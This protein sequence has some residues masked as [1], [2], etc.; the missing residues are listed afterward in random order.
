[1]AYQHTFVVPISEQTARKRIVT[2]YTRAGYQQDYCKEPLMI[3]KRGSHIGSWSSNPVNW[4]SVA[5][6]KIAPKSGFVEVTVT[7]E[8]DYSFENVADPYII[9]EV[10]LLG[11]VLAKD[12]YLPVTIEH[13]TRK[14]I[15][16]YARYFCRDLA[17][18]L[19][20]VVLA[21]ILWFVIV[22]ILRRF[23]EDM[24]VL[25]LLSLVIAMALTGIIFLVWDKWQKK[26]A[27]AASD[28]S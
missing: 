22:L 13:L 20:F 26:K 11:V 25:L 15:S 6:I 23:F 14:Q 17:K 2:Y 10:N 12:E 9:E 24:V 7:Y 8:T 16:H 27:K 5:R 28:T 21:A 18:E 19:A 3:F 1:M 4:Y